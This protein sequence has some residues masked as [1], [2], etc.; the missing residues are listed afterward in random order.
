MFLDSKKLSLGQ[1][2]S[3]FGLDFCL[4]L[5]GF[6]TIH[7]LFHI[8]FYVL[9]MF[10]LIGIWVLCLFSLCLTNSCPDS[11]VYKYS[12]ESVIKLKNAVAVLECGE[13]ISFG[14]LLSWHA[15]VRLLWKLPSETASSKTVSIIMVDIIV[16]LEIVVLRSKPFCTKLSLACVCCS[17]LFFLW[18]ILFFIILL[19]FMGAKKQSS[20]VWSTCLVHETHNLTVFFLSSIM[21]VAFFGMGQLKKG[22]LRS[23]HF[24]HTLTPRQFCNVWF[25]FM[26]SHSQHCCIVRSTSVFLCCCKICIQPMF[27]FSICLFGWVTSEKNGT[28]KQCQQ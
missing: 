26:K 10:D 25:V 24:K 19:L 12:Y 6:T 15:L 22:C 7:T 21:S 18:L 14:R 27:W 13:H 28:K 2:C 23:S 4:W 11:C 3:L 9:L 16:C 20:V 17:L 1:V 5:Y 8:I